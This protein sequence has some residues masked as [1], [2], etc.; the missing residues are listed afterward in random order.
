MNAGGRWNDQHGAASSVMGQE[1]W[2]SRLQ[3]ACFV[4]GRTNYHWPI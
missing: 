1:K 2:V 4:P 3:E